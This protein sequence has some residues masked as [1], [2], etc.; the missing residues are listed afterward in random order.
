MDSISTN[1]EISF[2][3]EFL[4]LIPAIADK[5]KSNID[6]TISQMTDK[7]ED[8]FLKSGEAYTKRLNLLQKLS[9]DDTFEIDQIIHL[10]SEAIQIFEKKGFSKG[11]SFLYAYLLC[12]KY[13]SEEE[14]K[15]NDYLT[16]NFSVEFL[17]GIDD[18]E[19]ENVKLEHNLKLSMF[20]LATGKKISCVRTQKLYE[21]I[22]LAKQLASLNNPPV[23]IIIPDGS[24]NNS[25][26]EIL[27]SNLY[28]NGFFELP[29][30]KSLSHDG[31]LKLIEMLLLNDT[32]YNV[33]LFEFIGFFKFLEF[34]K[35]LSKV[36][37]HKKTSAIFECSADT[38]KGNMLSLNDYSKIDKTRYTAHLHKEKVKTDYN[39]LK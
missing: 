26:S 17:A 16:D 7:S 1:S 15:I 14:N 34:E 12:M 38:I 2:F 32:P 18:K 28:D 33:A 21:S 24:K 6:S 22:D 3:D 29:K 23:E 25:K 19:F 5:L 39:S 10:H 35:S 4:S 36:A 11:Q 37:I 31:Q 30:V 9:L 20:E 8:G 27:K 13:I